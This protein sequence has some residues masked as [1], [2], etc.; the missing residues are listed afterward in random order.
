[1]KNNQTLSEHAEANGLA[2]I[3]DDDNPQGCVVRVY[4]DAFQPLYCEE[5]GSTLR[6]TDCW[7]RK[8]EE[9]KQ[10]ARTC[11]AVRA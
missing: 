5:I 11:K 2:T 7:A 8:Y 10:S 1:M 4:G 3:G 9:V 6:C